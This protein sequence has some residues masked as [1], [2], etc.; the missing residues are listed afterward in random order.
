METLVKLVLAALIA[1]GLKEHFWTIQSFRALVEGFDRDL[2]D[3]SILITL[4]L[5]IFLLTTLINKLKIW[6]MK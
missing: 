2:V 6:V 1:I 3:F 4:I 5:I